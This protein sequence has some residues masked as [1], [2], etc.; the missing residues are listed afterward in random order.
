V[1]EEQVVDVVGHMVEN[2]EVLG[3]VVVVPGLMVVVV[4]V[5]IVEARG[6]TTLG[7]VLVEFM[8]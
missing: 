2:M 5:V 1:G 3:V 7:P 4:V 6:L 8:A